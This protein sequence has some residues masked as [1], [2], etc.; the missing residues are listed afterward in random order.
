MLNRSLKPLIVLFL[1][2]PNINLMAGFPLGNVTTLPPPEKEIDSQ[3]IEII[4]SI[5]SLA[6]YPDSQDRH[7]YYYV[8]PF[9]VLPY[10]Q[11]AA[12]MVAH[13]VK[14]DNVFQADSIMKRMQ[15]EAV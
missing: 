2:L 12:T 15:S 1:L 5:L 10:D 11:G 6:V 4:S 8:P 14:A 3:D 9:R 13:T 7:L